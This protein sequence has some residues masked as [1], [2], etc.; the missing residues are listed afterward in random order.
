MNAK[1]L[2]IQQLKFAIKELKQ[3][4]TGYVLILHHSKD[5]DSHQYS[6]TEQPLDSP[7]EL[8]QLQELVGGYAE[9]LTGQLVFRAECRKAGIAMYGNEEAVPKKLP[10]SRWTSGEWCD[11]MMPHM[12]LRGDLV[13]LGVS[14][15]GYEPLTKTQVQF[16]M[17]S[18]FSEVF[19]SATYPFTIG[20]RLIAS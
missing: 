5:V 7:L 2:E 12:F 4:E 6:I 19:G 14:P 9:D 8:K 1:D 11:V 16:L 20:K 18:G 3:K 17:Y 10:K 13:F 15:S